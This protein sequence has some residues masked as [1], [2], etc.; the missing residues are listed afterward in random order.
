MV[1]FA[2]STAVMIPRMRRCVV[3]YAMDALTMMPSAA[4][5]PSL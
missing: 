5:T 2:G 4:N 3:P 1:T